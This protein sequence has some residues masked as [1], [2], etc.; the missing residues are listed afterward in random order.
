MYRKILP[1]AEF[2]R[3]TYTVVYV[4]GGIGKPN[5]LIHMNNKYN[6]TDQLLFSQSMSLLLHHSYIK[7]FL[8]KEIRGWPF[9]ASPF[10]K[11]VSTKPL[12]ANGTDRGSAPAVCSKVSE[13][14]P[15]DGRVG[16]DGRRDQS[17][18]SLSPSCF[19]RDRFWPSPE[20]T[21][22]PSHGQD[23]LAPSRSGSRR[24]PC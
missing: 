3:S 7:K 22:A 9:A 11:A 15:E 13:R 8:R 4:Y 20:I 1:S 23:S 16:G 19:F 24:H 18:S 12:P 6:T 5:K 21:P 10:R 17:P 2:S 14:S